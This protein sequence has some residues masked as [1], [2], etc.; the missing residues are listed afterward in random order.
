MDDPHFAWGK[1]A[2]VVV[3]VL[4]ILIGFI[5]MKRITSIFG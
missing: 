1:I 2:I 3:T 5:V 4:A